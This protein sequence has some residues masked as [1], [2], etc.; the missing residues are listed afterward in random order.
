MYVLQII[1]YVYVCADVCLEM[2]KEICNMPD[3]NQFLR[4]TIGSH[5]KDPVLTMSTN[6]PGRNTAYRLWKVDPHNPEF[7]MTLCKLDFHPALCKCMF[8]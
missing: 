4:A 7:F 6:I 8:S 2:S 1:M 5:H 3:T